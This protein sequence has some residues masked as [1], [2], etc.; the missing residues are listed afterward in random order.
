MQIP[1]GCGHIDPR[2]ISQEEYRFFFPS[3]ELVPVEFDPM[4]V[5]RGISYT[6]F[7]EKKADKLAPSINGR[8]SWIAT[9]TLSEY[10][11]MSK[12]EKFLSL[13]LDS[14]V[15]LDFDEVHQEA[16]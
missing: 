8:P 10:R 16:A 6:L 12:V 5:A 15:I 9:L 14:G 2:F 3:Q 7:K 1:E 13:L 4:A 11:K